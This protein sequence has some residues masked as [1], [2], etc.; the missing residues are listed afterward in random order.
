VFEDAAQVMLYKSFLLRIKAE[1]V[2][3]QADKLI[4]ES[5]AAR[6]E[7]K[8]LLDEMNRR[9]V[10][11]TGWTSWE[12]WIVQDGNEESGAAGFQPAGAPAAGGLKA[13]RSTFT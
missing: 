3:E 12:V 7:W 4:A 1:L 6:A 9:T 13:R 8:R 5:T 11:K 10:A 2:P